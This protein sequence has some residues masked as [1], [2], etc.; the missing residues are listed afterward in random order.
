MVVE[1]VDTLVVGAGQAGIAASEHLTN[2]GI[3]HVVLERDRIAE[4]WRSA[5]WD[6][7]VSNGPAWHDRFPSRNFD[8]PN[9]D[10]FISKEDVASYFVD[11]TEVA[12]TE[13]NEGS[14][15]IVHT[16]RC[17]YYSNIQEHSPGSNI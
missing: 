9:H 7:L 17:I 6:S 14:F 16:W 5:R 15:D 2:H 4:K 11:E 8:D 3:Q 10:A 12:D 13:Q 1:K